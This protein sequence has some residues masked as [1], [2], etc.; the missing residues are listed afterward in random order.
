MIGNIS[1]SPCSNRRN[2][3]VESRKRLIGLRTSQIQEDPFEQM[4]LFEDERQK[5]MR[6]MEKAVDHIRGRYGI[7]SVQRA[8]FLKENSPTPHAVSRKK[9]LNQA[10]QHNTGKEF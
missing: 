4:S 10:S 5:K 3:I 9:H 8:R 1:G 7:D 6:A 2:R